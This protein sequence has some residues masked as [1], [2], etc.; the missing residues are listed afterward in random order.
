M[1]EGQSAATVYL[2][3]AGPGDADLLTLRAARLI[4]AADVIF[5]DE[6]VTPEILSLAGPEAKLV[7][8]GKRSGAPSTGQD[9]IN[10]LLAEA[11]FPGKTVVRLKG[12]DPFIFGR[13]G[14]ELDYLRARGV[15]VEVVPGI[16]AALGCAA[17][18]QLPLTF[19]NEA[20]RL[21]LL[22][23]HRAQEAAAF[24]YAGLADAANT[25]AV[26]MGKETAGLFARELMAA[27]RA[28]GTPV[29]VVIN[30][31]RP[32]QRA[33]TGVLSGLGA[34][35]AAAGAGPALII[36]GE[37]VRHSSPWL[38]AAQSQSKTQKVA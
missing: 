27:G 6:L 31:T 7:N 18:A 34:L 11:A 21:T 24:D 8:V 19:R 13:G 15:N 33:L 38:A 2:V 29:A 36:V 26:Y 4:A 16:T 32:D 9:H 5:H 17:Q 12:G 28:P 10:R 30:G 37:V 20:L 22:T 14:E 3:G 23:A 35:A 1:R 25:L